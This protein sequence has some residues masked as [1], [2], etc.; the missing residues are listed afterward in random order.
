VFACGHVPQ[1]GFVWLL[2]ARERYGN[3]RPSHRQG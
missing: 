1:P 3:D 2:V